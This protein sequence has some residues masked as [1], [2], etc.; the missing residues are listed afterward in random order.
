MAKEKVSR[1]ISMV[2]CLL[3]LVT[4][5]FPT[6]VAPCSFHGVNSFYFLDESLLCQHRLSHLPVTVFRLIQ[7]FI[8]TFL[9]FS[10]LFP[11]TYLYQVF[12]TYYLIGI[13]FISTCQTYIWLSPK[14]QCA[15]TCQVTAMD[16][17]PYMY[18][19]I[20]KHKIIKLSTK[21]KIYDK[22]MEGKI[23]RATRTMWV[24][25]N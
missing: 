3:Q 21:L 24:D 17:G 16:K 4:W 1:I 2:A 23:W 19:V 6:V 11:I 5:A 22:H 9:P 15:D 12:K 25:L 18:P 7:L 14:A 10:F 8:S 13:Y 20:N